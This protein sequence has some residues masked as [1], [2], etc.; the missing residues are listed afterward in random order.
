[1]A[2]LVTLCYTEISSRRVDR[3]PCWGVETAVFGVQWGAFRLAEPPVL[4]V[5]VHA[6]NQLD[7][8]SEGEHNTLEA[9]SVADVLDR[10]MGVLAEDDR[11]NGLGPRA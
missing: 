9:E 1:M 5:V 11:T 4:A 7:G 10:E 2:F 3:V 6:Q 8:V